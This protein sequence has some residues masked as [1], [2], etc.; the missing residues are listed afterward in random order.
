LQ[1]DCLP[2]IAE[3]NEHTDDKTSRETNKVSTKD[4]CAYNFR[5]N[6]ALQK[7]CPRR[8]KINRK[9]QIYNNMDN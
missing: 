9:T 4:K 8:E 1:L 6:E 2:S 3:V 5:R 7:Y